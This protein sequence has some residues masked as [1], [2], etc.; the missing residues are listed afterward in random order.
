MNNFLGKNDRVLELGSGASLLKEF[1][2]MKI[3]TS[4]LSNQNFIDHRNIDAINTKFDN[5]SFDKVIS[6]NLIAFSMMD[7][8]QWQIYKL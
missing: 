1:I 7:Q 6:S 2:N 3:E 4:D 8:T 5:E